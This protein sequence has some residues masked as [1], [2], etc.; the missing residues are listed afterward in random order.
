MRDNNRDILKLFSDIGG[1]KENPF[2]TFFKYSK[3][4]TCT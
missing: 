4:N 3:N 2:L 1:Y